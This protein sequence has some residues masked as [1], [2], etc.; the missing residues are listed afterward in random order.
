MMYGGRYPSPVPPVL[1][2]RKKPSDVT[3]SQ[4]SI[5]TLGEY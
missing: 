2:V 5:F 4:D 3:V 1:R